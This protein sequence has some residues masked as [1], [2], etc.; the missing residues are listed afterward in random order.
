MRLSI[1][2]Q[3]S[4]NHSDL[5]TIVGQFESNE[6]AQSAYDIWMRLI[7]GVIEWHQQNSDPNY[8]VKTPIEL[9]Y[10]QWYKFPD[11]GWAFDWFGDKPEQVIDQY[12][13]LLAVS[14]VKETVMLSI[15][16]EALMEALGGKVYVSYL[17]VCDVLLIISG[18]APDDA[19][20]Q[21]V[22]DEVLAGM[23]T[24]DYDEEDDDIAYI[25]I[26]SPEALKGEYR[27]FE[28][29]HQNRTVTFTAFLLEG[30]WQIGDYLRSQG[31]TNLH[32]DVRQIFDD[33]EDE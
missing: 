5:Y 24:E 15:V 26:E 12:D 11:Q 2:Q 32:Q 28:V 16:P 14:T 13:D 7:K 1:W 33:A 17:D 3:F 22:Y 4:S 25:V 30:G 20:A 31:F 6:A 10:T 29:E 8:D 23:Q 9:E 27:R 19:T 21:R 18:V